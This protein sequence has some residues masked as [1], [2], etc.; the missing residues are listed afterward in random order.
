MRNLMVAD[1]A[2]LNFAFNPGLLG[3]V[4]VITGKAVALAFDERDKVIKHEQEFTAIAY[5]AWANRGPGEMVV[6]IPNS[7]MSARPLPRPTLAS[8]SKVTVSG[9]RNARAIN[10][11]AEPRSSDDAS[12]TYFHWWP[13]KGTHRMG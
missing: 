6:W 5:Y 8:A 11:Q 12:N 9:G 13:K 3:G 1:D 4:T 10:D 2:R 7:E